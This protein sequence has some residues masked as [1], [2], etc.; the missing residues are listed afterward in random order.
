MGRELIISPRAKGSPCG[1]PA[2]NATGA[3]DP[4]VSEF[5]SHPSPPHPKGL[6][7]VPLR[8]RPSNARG[9]LSDFAAFCSQPVFLRPSQTSPIPGHRLLH[10]AATRP[11]SLLGYP[12]LPFSKKPRTGFTP[13]ASHLPSLVSLL[14]RPSRRGGSFTSP[15]FPPSGPACPRLPSGIA[16]TGGRPR[17]RP[18]SLTSGP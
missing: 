6:I 10:S 5:G 2:R 14:Y 7:G 15:A 12:Q 8:P 11:L 16:E 9:L 3:T 13:S 1:Y 18:L 4:L 17:P